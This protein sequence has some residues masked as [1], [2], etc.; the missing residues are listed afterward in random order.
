M[1]SRITAT[2]AVSLSLLFAEL[3]HAQQEGTVPDKARELSRLAEAYSGV[4]RVQYDARGQTSDG[5]VKLRRHATFDRETR[6]VVQDFVSTKARPG[7]AWDALPIYTVALDGR[8]MRS[9]NQPGTFQETS[10]DEGWS[11]VSGAAQLP[12]GPWPY[13]PEIAQMIADDP[14]SSVSKTAAGFLAR[15]RVNKCEISW[16]TQW[17]VTEFRRLTSADGESY[18]LCQYENHREAG[19]M[20]VPATIREIVTVK[21]QGRVLSQKNEYTRIEWRI[22]DAIADRELVFD[23]EALRLNRIDPVT[24]DVF[25]P[26]GTFLFN[27]DTGAAQPTAAATRW[28]VTIMYVIIGVAAVV[29]GG[30]AYRRCVAGHGVLHGKA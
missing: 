1:K 22:N 4:R 17:N 24:R 2:F 18:V 27:A 11:I 29:S 7:A 16:D 15:S 20:Q 23:P 28:G 19:G 26:S 30:A 8:V 10:L 25:T 21:T 6:F 13:V 5:A 12:F 9:G 3:S 14:D